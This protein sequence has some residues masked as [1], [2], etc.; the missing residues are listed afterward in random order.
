VG[1]AGRDRQASS[2]AADLS[3]PPRQADG[4]CL[5]NL[6]DKRYGLLRIV[7]V[8]YGQA[9]RVWRQD[10]SRTEVGFDDQS[11]QLSTQWLDL[12]LYGA[13]IGCRDRAGGKK[14]RRTSEL[15]HNAYAAH[16]CLQQIPF[17]LRIARG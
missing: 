9:A 13:G 17:I 10:V 6:I 2:D 15:S 5:L 12:S 14:L 8:G 1:W 11:R 3:V 4:L 7:P 16:V